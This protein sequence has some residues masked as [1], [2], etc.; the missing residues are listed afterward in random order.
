ML[1][2]EKSTDEVV[3]VNSFIH[4]SVEKISSNLF[5]VPTYLAVTKDSL[6]FI[7]F[8]AMTAAIWSRS[9]YFSFRDGLHGSPEVFLVN[10]YPLYVAHDQAISVQLL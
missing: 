5:Y 3:S 9:H 10:G 7:E 8:L 1:G 4:L 6:L 2:S